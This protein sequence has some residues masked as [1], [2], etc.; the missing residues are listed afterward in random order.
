M[1]DIIHLNYRVFGN[2]HPVIFLHGFLESI[3]MWN[4]LNLESTPFKN[5]LIDLPGHGDSQLLDTNEHPSM[6]FMASKVKEVI[7][8]LGVEKY[9]IVG[10]SMGGYVALILKEADARCEKVI[11]LNSNFW[12]DSG[13]KKKDRI[14]VA[15]IVL[16]SKNLFIQEAIPGLFYR[17]DRKGKI[18][19]DLIKETQKID[20]HAIA[21]STLAMRNR[22]NY[23]DL[24]IKK[25]SDFLLIQGEKDP[26]ISL[27]KM[28]SEIEEIEIE[29]NIVE[30][31]GHMSHIE[32]PEKT[33]QL[34]TKFLL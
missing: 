2:G 23:R 27:D 22:Q 34:I 16:K 32:A 18:V 29:L 8:K 31:S 30:N 4:N 14:R 19:Q 25:P 11:L 33:I 12:E 13:E 21:Y 24:L 1:K 6:E 20:A 9:H 17:H 28:I 7:D 15:D 3:S 10:H 5:V 26:L